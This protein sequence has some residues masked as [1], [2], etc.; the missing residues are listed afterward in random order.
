MLKRQLL[1]MLSSDNP[2]PRF[3]RLKR[4]CQPHVSICSRTCASAPGPMQT[5]GFWEELA[6][7]CQRFVVDV[8]RTRRWMFNCLSS[9]QNSKRLWWNPAWLLR[10][11]H[12]KSTGKCVPGS[13]AKSDWPS[14][15]YYS[16]SCLGRTT[17]APLSAEFPSTSL[18]FSPLPR[19]VGFR[20]WQTPLHQAIDDGQ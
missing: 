14:Q 6:I 20:F 8:L 5:E 12:W 1:T 11:S 13:A 19:A 4:Q 16:N 17:L 3:A 2:V 10:S 9:S 7:L 18:G 15:D